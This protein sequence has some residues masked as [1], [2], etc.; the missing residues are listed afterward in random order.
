[1]PEDHAHVYSEAV[2]RGGT[3]VSVKADDA[4]AAR[5]SSILE[6]HQPVDPD[7]LGAKYRQSGWREFDPAA[8]PYEV[9][10]VEREGMRR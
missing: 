9:S 3:L 1:V 4:Q 6:S 5:V 2:R 7:R 10:K 8:A